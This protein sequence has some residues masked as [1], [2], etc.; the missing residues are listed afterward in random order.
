M[1]ESITLPRPS[2][3]SNLANVGTSIHVKIGPTVAQ[4][5]G[6]KREK[7]NGEY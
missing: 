6:R 5:G 4:K 2:R 1:R 3:K 7:N